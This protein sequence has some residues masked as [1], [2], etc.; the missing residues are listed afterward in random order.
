MH[1]NQGKGFIQ[2]AIQRDESPN[3]I[4]DEEAESPKEKM[5]TKKTLNEISNEN[6]SKLT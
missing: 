5:V 6:F 4:P 1:Q 3:K 2:Q